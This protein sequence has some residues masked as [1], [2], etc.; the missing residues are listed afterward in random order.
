M[1]LFRRIFISIHKR[2]RFLGRNYQQKSRK[3]NSIVFITPKTRITN[4]RKRISISNFESRNFISICLF[5]RKFQIEFSPMGSVDPIH[6]NLNSLYVQL[7][8]DSLT[9]FVYPA[10]LGG[11]QYD[12]SALNYGIQVSPTIRFEQFICN[13]RYLVNSSW[14]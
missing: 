11:L 4:S 1:N 9:E 7:V 12:L 3:M 5:V 2:K 8:E 6:S 13:I 10:Q 14:I